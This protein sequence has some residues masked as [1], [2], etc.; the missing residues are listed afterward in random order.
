MF[1][2]IYDHKRTYTRILSDRICFVKPV[3]RALDFMHPLSAYVCVSLRRPNAAM[4]KQH[5]NV[6]DVNTAF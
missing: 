4:P 6:S 1:V 3:Q 5:L 2:L